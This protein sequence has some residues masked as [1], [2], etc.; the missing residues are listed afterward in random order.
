[1]PHSDTKRTLEFVGEIQAMTDN[2]P[3]KSIRDMRA[4]DG[5]LVGCLGFMA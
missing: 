3:S 5:W 2:G 1:M 4:S